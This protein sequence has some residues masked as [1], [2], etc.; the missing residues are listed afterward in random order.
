MVINEHALVR[1]LRIFSS[2]RS[3]FLCVDQ[4]AI[5]Y[6]ITQNR[7]LEDIRDIIDR[8]PAIPDALRV[9]NNCRPK[10]AHTKTSGFIGANRF[11]KLTPRQMLFKFRSDFGRALVAAGFLGAGSIPDIFTDKDVFGVTLFY[12]IFPHGFVSIN[13]PYP[14]AIV[15]LMQSAPS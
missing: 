15:P 2:G 5:N 14:P 11:R 12:H 7:A 4:Q 1:I 10:L 13:L 6:L 9:N 3:R 8:Y